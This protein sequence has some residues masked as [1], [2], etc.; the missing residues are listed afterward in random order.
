MTTAMTM[1]PGATPADLFPLERPALLARAA[2]AG[3]RSYR[4]LR[5]LPGAVHGLLAASEEEILP[6]LAVAEAEYEAARRAG[7][8]GYRVGRHVQVLAALLAEAG[9]LA[10]QPKAS[11]SSALRRAM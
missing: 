6:R 4:R 1:A 11:G 9:R 7:A 2:S 5:D 3:A 10:A 8:A